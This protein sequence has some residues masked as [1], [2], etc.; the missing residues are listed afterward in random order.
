MQHKMYPVFVDNISNDVKTADLRNV[1]DRCGD[2]IEVTIVSNHG[3]VIFGNPDHALEAIRKVDGHE[4][5]GRRLTVDVSKELEDYLQGRNKKEYSDDNRGHDRPRNTFDRENFRGG[6]GGRGDRGRRGWVHR[7]GRGRGFRG[8]G[9]RGY[10]RFSPNSRNDRRSRSPRDSESYQYQQDRNRSPQS[11]RY[12]MGDEKR[13]SFSPM[14]KTYPPPENDD[15]R[16]FHFKGSRGSRGKSKPSP[17]RRG[18]NIFPSRES[19]TPSPR[20]STSR[21]RTRSPSK[22][23]SSYRSK[24]SRKRSHRS[25]S[26]SRSQ[27]RGKIDSE[28]TLPARHSLESVAEGSKGSKMDS[29]GF[30]T[31]SNF[32]ETK[33][34]NKGKSPCKPPPATSPITSTS[35]NDTT[36]TSATNDDEVECGYQKK[37]KDDPAAPKCK[38]SPKSPENSD[39]ATN[40]NQKLDDPESSVTADKEKSKKAKKSSKKAESADQQVDLREILKNKKKKEQSKS[41]DEAFELPPVKRRKSSSNSTSFKN[42]TNIQIKVERES[43]SVRTIMVGANEKSK[44]VKAFEDTLTETEADLKHKSTLPPPSAR[45]GMPPTISPLTESIKF[46]KLD[47]DKY[48]KLFVG[49]LFNPVENEDLEMLLEEFGTVYE[50]KRYEKHAIVTVECSKERSDEA[51]RALDHNNWMDNWIRVKPNRYPQSKEEAD[52]IY[53]SKQTAG[54]RNMNRW[55]AQHDD[56]DQITLFRDRNPSS[57]STGVQEERE[58]KKP[59]PSLPKTELDTKFIGSFSKSDPEDDTKDENIAEIQEKPESNLT[60]TTENLNEQLEMELADKLKK[61]RG[62]GRKVRSFRIYCATS[63]KNFMSEMVEV[64]TRFGAVKS[65]EWDGPCIAIDLESTEKKAVQCIFETNKI[66]YKGQE[67]R[68]KFKDGTEED[69]M[70]FQEIYEV[71]FRNYPKDLVPTNASQVRPA[72]AATDVK[73]TSNKVDELPIGVL[74]QSSSL[75]A[76]GAPGIPDQE[77]LSSIIQKARENMIKS[78][79]TTNKSAL[80]N[81]ST[82]APKSEQL[83][84]AYAISTAPLTDDPQYLSEVE[85]RIHSVNNRIVLIQFHTGSSWRLTKLSPGTMYVDGKKCLGY[86]IKNNTF[87]SWP[88]VLKTF[89]YQGAKVKMD[90]KRMYDEEEINEARE[91]CGESVTYSTPLVWKMDTSKPTEKDITISRLKQKLTVLKGSVTSIYPK[92]GVIGTNKGEVFFEV[93]HVYIDNK[94]F[95]KN[96]SLLNHIEKGDTLAVQCVNIPDY[97]EMSEIARSAPGFAGRTDTLKFHAR[98]VWHLN[99]EVDPYSVRESGSPDFSDIECNYLTTSSTLNKPLPSDRE[100]TARPTKGWSGRVEEIHLPAGGVILLDDHLNLKPFERYAYFHRSRVYANGS[101]IS[102][103]TSLDDE[104]VPGDRVTVDVVENMQPG[105]IKKSN[106]YVASEAYWVAL[107][108]H[109]NSN[110]RGVLIARSLRMEV[111]YIN[112]QRFQE[113]AETH[114]KHLFQNISF[115]RDYQKFVILIVSLLSDKAKNILKQSYTLFLNFSTTINKLFWSKIVSLPLVNYPEVSCLPIKR[116]I[117]WN[118]NNNWGS[119]SYVV[120]ENYTLYMNY[121]LFVSGLRQC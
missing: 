116:L 81:L 75:G 95:E 82:P 103:S 78:E 80:P 43:E 63:N 38:K 68:V 16:Y 25:R 69:K 120:H 119:M 101:K 91:I 92:W 19:R 111:D 8:R 15:G 9:R 32:V 87:H 99:A 33:I 11:R 21:S 57:D 36:T 104:I 1:F 115:F 2:V 71:E 96:V 56:R 46:E 35:A 42:N 7:G 6:R 98:L 55:Y 22:Y 59:K 85:G 105:V 49:N 62:I 31:A 40:V 52:A 5:N 114:D 51:C 10:G 108:V 30:F 47:P 90:V 89:L 54:E 83:Y 110:E 93:N 94:K 86:L 58:P 72:M 20:R 29:F 97:L 23:D 113:T 77:M 88:Q 28:V 14:V 65:N 44:Q 118:N 13:R 79:N 26:S 17:P 112:N 66:R 12:S 53:R 34:E 60:A 70:E 39:E 76:F 84:N 3:F 50:I 73:T 64:F 24:S 121:I 45:A 18:Q 67:L 117:P 106:A 4:L 27:S 107:S 61:R 74:P 100:I 102:S 48:Q 109:L 41:V 37:E